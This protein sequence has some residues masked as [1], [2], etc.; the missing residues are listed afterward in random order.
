MDFGKVFTEQVP[1]VAWCHFTCKQA[2][3]LWENPLGNF[4]VPPGKNVLDVL[5]KLLD[6]V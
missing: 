5:K 1:A 2:R 3:N 6:I 4:F